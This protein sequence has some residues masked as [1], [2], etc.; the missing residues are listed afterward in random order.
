[1]FLSLPLG[2]VAEASLWDHSHEKTGGHLLPSLG[3]EAYPKGLPQCDR[4]AAEEGQKFLK[5]HVASS[6]AQNRQKEAG[7]YFYRKKRMQVNITLLELRMRGLA[8]IREF[9]HHRQHSTFLPEICLELPIHA[10]NK[11]K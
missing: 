4:R 9:T 11:V 5:A 7:Y 3:C 2:T 6:P 1:M 8:H 10:Q